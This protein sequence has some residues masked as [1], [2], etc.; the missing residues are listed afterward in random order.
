MQPA[1]RY[2]GNPVD[3]TGTAAVIA[4][5]RGGPGAEFTTLIR[6]YVPNP[7]A[8][9]NQLASGARSE[10]LIPGFAVRTPKLLDSYTGPRFDQF[11]PTAAGWSAR[12]TAP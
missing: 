5:L 10:L 6:R 4:A 9:I 8:V 11:N 7:L 12:R 3:G 1:L 2:P